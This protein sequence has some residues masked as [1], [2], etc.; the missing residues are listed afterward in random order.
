[1]LK[2][3]KLKVRDFAGFISPFITCF[4]LCPDI[5]AQV[6]LDT[7]IM[8]THGPPHKILD[9]TGGGDHTGC[10]ELWK[11]LKTIQ[12]RLHVFGHVHESRGAMIH[13]WSLKEV[14]EEKGEE[15]ECDSPETVFVNASCQPAGPLYYG[16][17]SDGAPSLYSS[18]QDSVMI[19][20]RTA[21]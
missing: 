6:P 1:M 14:E 4:P 21:P 13:T 7:E 5:Y 8:V 10:E 11:R 18:P 3:K 2:A 15:N 12:P 19:I 16:A 9:F 17:L 20:L